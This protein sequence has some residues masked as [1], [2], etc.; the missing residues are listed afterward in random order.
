ML[1]NAYEWYAE[2]DI[3]QLFIY[4]YILYYNYDPVFEFQFS[5]VNC[6]QCTSPKTNFIRFKQNS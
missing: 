3:E 2:E 6:I 1:K 5:T 4:I